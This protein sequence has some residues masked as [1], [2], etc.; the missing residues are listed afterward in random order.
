MCGKHVQYSDKY[1]SFQ[2]LLLKTGFPGLSAFEDY[3]YR[4]IGSF[5]STQD[6]LV[7]DQAVLFNTWC[8]LLNT[9][10]QMHLKKTISISKIIE[11]K[12]HVVFI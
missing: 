7:K 11:R 4:Y 2:G 12:S 1:V 9:E 5:V 6:L 10:L 8:L 3:S